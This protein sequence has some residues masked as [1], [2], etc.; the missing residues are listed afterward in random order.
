MGPKKPIINNTREIFLCP[1]LIIA[2][3]ENSDTYLVLY[4]VKSSQYTHITTDCNK[5]NE[6]ILANNE[7]FFDD[8][9][10]AKERCQV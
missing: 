6:L 10:E 8:I 7:E 4:K 2:K 5:Y 3:D 9:G 1:T